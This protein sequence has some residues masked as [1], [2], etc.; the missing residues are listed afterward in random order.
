VGEQQNCLAVRGDLRHGKG[1]PEQ[2][3]ER[4]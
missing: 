3:W 2:G 4:R 1:L